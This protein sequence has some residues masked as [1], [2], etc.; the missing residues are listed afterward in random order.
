MPGP[1]LARLERLARC[2]LVLRQLDDHAE[3]VRVGAAHE[4]RQLAGRH[5]LGQGRED[6][7]LV[8][9]RD[10]H[11]RPVG[12]ALDDRGR[13]VLRVEGSRGV[14]IDTVDVDV[15]EGFD[16]HAGLQWCVYPG[17]DSPLPQ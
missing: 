7:D 9:E 6:R 16:L 5:A 13:G 3:A 4:V 17:P 8:A 11:A 1:G 15:I 10:Q 12:A 14:R 2:D